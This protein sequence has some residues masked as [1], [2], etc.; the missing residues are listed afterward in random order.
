ML[1]LPSTVLVNRVM[2][3]KVFYEHLK[4]TAAIKEQFVQQ[5]ERIE[6][7]AS[8]KEASIHIPGDKDVAE[9]DVLALHLKGAN[10]P[11]EAIELVARSI[12]NK[13][14][15]VCL[16]DE[17]CKLL[18]RRDRLYETEWMPPDDAKLELAGSTL[19]ELWDAIVTQVVFGDD[20]SVDL[21]GRLERKRRSE[22]LRLELEQ[23]ERK[24]KSEKQIAKRNA[25]FDRKRTIE[26]EL[27]RLEG[28]S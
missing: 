22:A 1:N 21:A 19:G 28:E 20:N 25:L 17:S 4:T 13:L 6:M 23:V 26:E 27:S 18:V 2:P 7:V 15:F 11:Y 8:I 3:K 14:L 9:I 16:S 12:P 24:R 10:V 5:I